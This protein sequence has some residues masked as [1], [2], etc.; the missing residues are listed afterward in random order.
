MWQAA[1]SGKSHGKGKELC[2]HITCDDLD[3]IKQSIDAENAVTMGS[4]AKLVLD[5]CWGYDSG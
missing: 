1:L 2:C 4:I 5:N 3:K